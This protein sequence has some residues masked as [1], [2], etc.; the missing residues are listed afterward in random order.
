MNISICCALTLSDTALYVGGGFTNAANMATAGYVARWAT[1]AILFGISVQNDGT[2]DKLKLKAT[3]T[4][5]A[6]YTVKYFKGATGITAAVVAGTYQTA[7]LAPWRGR[8]DHREGGRQGGC[9]LGSKVTCLVTII[10]VGNPSKKDAVKF[11]G[12]RA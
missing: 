3:S 10:S 1:A 4:N 5:V 8:A 9:H 11:T 2:T 12:K 6:G 7:S